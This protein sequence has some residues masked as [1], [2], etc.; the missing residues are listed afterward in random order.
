MP[1]WTRLDEKWIEGRYRF[2]SFPAGIR[3][4]DEIAIYAEEKKHHPVISIDYKVV[5][6]K[7]SSW[8]VKGLRDIDFAMGQHFDEI[9]EEMEK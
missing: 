9:Y 2:K 7:M 1:N 5:T 8:Q 4:V 6:L 3:F